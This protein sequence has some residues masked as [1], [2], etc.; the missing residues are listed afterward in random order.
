MSEDLI[1]N[2]LI[3]YWKSMKKK[4]KII[5]FDLDYTLWP[6]YVDCH[7]SPPIIKTN[8]KTTY[9][10][11]KIIDSSGL[12]M[13]GFKDVNKILYT[14]KN[15]CL[16][17]QNNEYLAI[18]SRSTT[19]DLALETIEALGWTKYFSSFQIYPS[20][21]TIHMRKIIEELQ[22]NDYE[23]IL[24]FDDEYHNIKTTQSLKLTPIEINPSVGLDMKTL[25]HGFERFQSKNK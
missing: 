5:V 4:P 22:M 13:N 9:G 21:K 1:D 8:E 23:S 14:L 24:F 6:Y 2:D 7:A 11:Q 16:N 25:I 3:N 15:Y 17:E 20:S 10:A 12:Q 19:R 18:A